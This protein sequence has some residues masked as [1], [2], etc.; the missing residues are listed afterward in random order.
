MLSNIILGSFTIYKHLLTLKKSSVG[1]VCAE[2]AV[3][4]DI[5]PYISPGITPPPFLTD[6]SILSRWPRLISCD[7][8]F[9]DIQMHPAYTFL[10]AKQVL[11][12]V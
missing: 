4:V 12:K 5:T 1:V 10:I 3:W 2:T 7:S 6:T 11:I 9:I 8:F